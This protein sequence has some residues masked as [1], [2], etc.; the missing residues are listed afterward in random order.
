LFKNLPPEEKKRV[1]KEED[2]A[3]RKV[4]LEEWN[5]MSEHQ[6]TQATK[7]RRIRILN[8]QRNLTEMA[9]RMGSKI[10]E[11][12]DSPNQ[13][14]DKQGKVDFE[15]E[16]EASNRGRSEAL[17]NSRAS[18]TGGKPGLGSGERSSRPAGTKFVGISIPTSRNVK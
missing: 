10:E 2:N 6:Q 11:E 8:F 15:I 12:K 18:G 4:P 14:K 1:R 17:G 5:K 9:L 7:E 3:Y 16:E 13:T